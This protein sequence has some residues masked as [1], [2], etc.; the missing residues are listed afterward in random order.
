MG[1]FLFKK[2]LTMPVSKKRKYDRKTP[3]RYDFV[4]FKSSIFDDS[5]DFPKLETAPLRVIEA[6]NTGEVQHVSAW[7]RDAGVDPDA[8]EAYRDLSQDELMEFIE[9]WTAGQPV[10]IPK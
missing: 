3:K 5:F 7:L 4:T 2:G 1:A 8:I 6:M 9:E 10:T